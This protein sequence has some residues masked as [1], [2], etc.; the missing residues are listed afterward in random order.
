MEAGG[1]LFISF[2][3]LAL[4]SVLIFVFY[5]ESHHNSYNCNVYNN[6][7]MFSFSL[8][9]HR[10]PRMIGQIDSAFDI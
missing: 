8:F 10:I 4:V 3:T 9:Q 2:L 6:I 7:R 1:E 5:L